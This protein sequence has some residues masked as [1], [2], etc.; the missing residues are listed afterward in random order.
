MAPRLSVVRTVRLHVKIGVFSNE[1]LAERRL[2]EGLKFF[3]CLE[4]V[5][6]IYGSWDWERQ[7]HDVTFLAKK[8]KE[9]VRAAV[10][11]EIN[12]RLYSK[13]LSTGDIQELCET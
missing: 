12:V 5:E 7:L 9:R 8:C 6:V 13:K 3:P 11:S 4:E 10:S 1:R 2:I